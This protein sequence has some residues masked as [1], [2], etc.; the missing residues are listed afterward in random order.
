MKDVA[1]ACLVLLLGVT[2][3][4]AKRATPEEARASELAAR[5][6]N[7]AAAATAIPESVRTQ[8]KAA[9]ENDLRSRAAKSSGK[10][11]HTLQSVD[12]IGDVSD[13][14]LRNRPHAYDIVVSYTVRWRPPASWCPPSRHAVSATRVAWT[15]WLPRLRKC[16]PNKSCLP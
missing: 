5:A 10:Y 13:Y 8:T 6:S 4:A 12:F 16:I 3:C 11:T 9:C 2:G 14:S 1:V 7:S 15:G